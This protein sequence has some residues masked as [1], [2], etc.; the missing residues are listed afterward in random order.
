MGAEGLV[1]STLT[2]KTLRLREEWSE[3]V[4]YY[5]SGKKLVTWAWQASSGVEVRRWKSPAALNSRF[6]LF[7]VG[8]FS[9]FWVGQFSLFWVQSS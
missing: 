3:V 2:L 8:Q 5:V 7:R 9:L 1:S 4:K 6:S